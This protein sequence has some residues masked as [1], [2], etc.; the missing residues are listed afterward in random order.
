VIAD[1]HHRYETALAYRDERRARAGHTDPNAPYEKVMMTLFN[2]AVEGLTILPTH[3]VV[4]NVA[5]FSFAAFRSALADLFDVK[6]H[7]FSAAADRPRAYE[8]FRRDLVRGSEQRAIG[9][10]AGGGLF[11]IFTLKEGAN[12]DTLLPGVSPAQTRLDVVLLHRL[13]LERGLK[14][15]PDAVKTEKNL[16]YEREMDTAI[17]EV[18]SG[19]AQICFLLNPVS[20]ETVAE[21]AM[22]GEVLPQKSTDFFPKLMSGITM[23]RL[24]D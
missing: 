10:Y 11:H 5:N 18:D 12:L 7:P 3:R 24:K 9:V 19:R 2:T 1:G 8:Q 21:M 4:A 6:S 17:A 14:I 13:M 22:G 20:V 16:T 23:Y 15:T